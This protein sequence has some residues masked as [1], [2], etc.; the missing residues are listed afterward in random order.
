MADREA[1]LGILNY[2]YLPVLG[3]DGDAGEAAVG[4]LRTESAPIWQRARRR[5]GAVLDIGMEHKA[6]PNAV[7]GTPAPG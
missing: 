3:D 5:R 7:G 1:R 6:C 4:R 2:R